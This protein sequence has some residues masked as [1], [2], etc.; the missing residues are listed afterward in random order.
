MKLI[1]ISKKQNTTKK[2]LGY[3]E[4]YEKYFEEIRYNKLKILEIG[5]ENGG[6][7]RTWK[8]YFPKAKI[9]GLDIKKMNFN[10]K[11]V[12][13]IQGDQSSSEI[14]NKII[15]KYKSFDIIIDDGSHL[16]KHVIKSFKYLFKA[17]KNDGLYIIEDLQTSYFP[18]YGGSRINLRKKSTSLNFFKDLTDSIN[19]EKNDKPFFYKSVF[20]GNIKFVHFYQNVVVV[21]KGSSRKLFY[22]NSK[23]N[24]SISN[25]IKKT[26]S[27]LFK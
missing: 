3:F 8:R 19:Y 15:K 25:L 9:I 24:L 23:K 1:K 12:D 11:N 5:I 14:L 16:T 4:I 7:I 13:L 2:G 27:Y 22:K 17:L 10:I 18:R 21:K 6:S 20:D 26:I